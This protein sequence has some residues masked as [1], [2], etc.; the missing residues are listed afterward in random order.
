MMFPARRLDGPVER[1]VVAALEAVGAGRSTVRLPAMSD[2]FRDELRAQ[3]VAVTPRLV[4]EG[5]RPGTETAP[6]ATASTAGT[7]TAS[8]AAD[9]PSRRAAAA[10]R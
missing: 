9:R 7:R 4:A 5:V 6:R 1:K 2:S 3:L 10:P 8:R